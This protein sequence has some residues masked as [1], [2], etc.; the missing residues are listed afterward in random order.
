V[1]RA[2]RRRLRRALP[3]SAA[4]AGL[5]RVCR[6]LPRLPGSAA[7]AGLCRSARFAASAPQCNS[8]A[9]VPHN[10]V[11]E[12]H[13][14]PPCPSPGAHCPRTVA[15]MRRLTIT[16]AA[17]VLAFVLLVPPA[18]AEWTWPVRGEVITPYRNGTD[19]YASGQHRGI[20]IA[21]ATGAT[22]VAATSG[23]V[24]FAG[25]AGSSG[26]TVSV[27]TADGR[28]DTSYLHLSSTSVRDGDRVAAGQ[29]LGAV[30]T[31]GTRSAAQPHLHF[32]VRD[33]GSR[34]A[35]HDPLGFLPPPTAEPPRGVPAPEPAPV[36]VSPAP[37]PGTRPVP[38]PAPAPRR[39]PVGA[40]R[41]VPVGAPRR[42]PDGAPRRVPAGERRRVPAG[43]PRRGPVGAPHRVPLGAPRSV[44]L[45]EPRSVP[46]G[47]PR[48]VPQGAPRGV[49]LGAPRGVPLGE[50]RSV[51]LGEPRSVPQGAPGRVPLE[52]PLRVPDG[53][54][55]RAPAAATRRVA[56]G[57]PHRVSAGEAGGASADAR[58]FAS[59]G[60][61]RHDQAGLDLGLLA[62]CLGVLAAAALLALTGDRRHVTRRTGRRIAR[63]LQPTLGRR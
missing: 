9:T 10:S 63:V 44:P 21:A 3:G 60:A 16:S 57:E 11:T 38:I 45:G 37:A 25:S 8:S 30:G 55:G 1:R 41:R 53:A 39:V 14:R 29:P 28:Y 43:A 58:R 31:T 33:A 5:C 52:S 7:S 56:A 46:L 18:W 61:P 6:A 42:V 12:R 54:P 27:R 47:E 17:T 50:P 49:P 34:H 48:R 59:P 15:A 13:N 24:R 51:P 23:E 62:A 32:G 4:S 2:G 26:L 36:P 22:V 40:P 20:D 35:Y 19:P